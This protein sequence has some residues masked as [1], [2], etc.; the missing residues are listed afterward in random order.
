MNK[1]GLLLVFAASLSFAQQSAAPAQLT[2]L[3]PKRKEL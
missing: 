3:P 2:P 1:L